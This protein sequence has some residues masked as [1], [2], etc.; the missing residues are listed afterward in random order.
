MCPV[1]ASVRIVG[2]GAAS[3]R[4]VCYQ[5]CYQGP[6]LGPVAHPPEDPLERSKTGT[7]GVRWADDYD[8][9]RGFATRSAAGRHPDS[10]YDRARVAT[11]RTAKEV[12]VEVFPG[13]TMDPDV[14]FGKPC[15][16]GT[17]VDV[18]T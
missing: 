15:I 1:R 10:H 8:C 16:A 5:V 2:A 17:R 14:R 4:A 11:A 13:I 3:C 18:A 7:G 12:A 9:D 6:A